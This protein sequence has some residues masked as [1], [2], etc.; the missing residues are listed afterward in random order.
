MSSWYATCSCS[1]CFYECSVDDRAPFLE[2]R[3]SRARAITNQ[4]ISNQPNLAIAQQQRAIPSKSSRPA[5]TAKEQEHRTKQPDDRE[6]PSG[7]RRQ[8]LATSS[9]RRRRALR[10]SPR[11]FAFNPNKAAEYDPDA[12]LAPPEGTSVKPA[13]PIVGASTVTE[14]N[15]SEKVG[16]GGPNIGQNPRSARSIA[17]AS[18]PP[19]GC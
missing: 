9:P 7:A 11:R 12:A 3:A 5:K 19:T 13:D 16:G 1:S 18:I 17:C 6:W 15:G 14:L 10:T 4:T 2:R 8:G